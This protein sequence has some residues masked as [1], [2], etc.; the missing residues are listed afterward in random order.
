MPPRVD[1][2][3]VTLTPDE[4]AIHVTGRGK[5]Q[6]LV[7]CAAERQGG[8]FSGMNALQIAQDLASVYGITV[9]GPEGLPVIPQFNLM[10]TETPFSVIERICRSAALL[11]YEEP[12][13]G[14]RLANVEPNSAA[15]GPVEGQNVQ[16][17]EG[18]YTMAERYSEYDVYLQDLDVW[19][20]AGAGGNMIGQ[21]KDPN[22]PRHRKMALIAENGS[23]GKDLAD[24][25]AVWESTR[26]IGRGFELRVT[27]DSWRD[28]AGTLWTP[29][30]IIP[31]DLP[32]LKV[33]PINNNWV[34][35]EVTHSRDSQG[36]RAELVI[37][38]DIA[39]IPEPILLQPVN[40]DLKLPPKA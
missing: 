1:E 3:V 9:R 24:V 20:D 27:V 12:D 32:S 15:S 2:V 26:R 13:G 37:Q 33:P 30:T 7:D 29:N 23:G 31:I 18:R 6:D 8:Q 21:A 36:T 38:P 11:C 10:M 22:V 19:A 34:L 16:S 35:G 4:H 39:F 25:R 5:C 14:L 40:A 28:A 17:A